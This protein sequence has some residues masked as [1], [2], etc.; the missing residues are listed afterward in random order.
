M[1]HPEPL[2]L[3]ELLA[4]YGLPPGTAGAEHGVAQEQFP[5][6]GLYGGTPRRIGKQARAASSRARSWRR[7]AVL[8]IGCPV[9]VPE[10]V[11][12]D[13]G[14]PVGD[15]IREPRELPVRIAL[16]TSATVRRR[17]ARSRKRRRSG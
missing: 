12:E 4:A 9:G 13:D 17:R 1:D 6:Q 16:R 14:D 2:V 15:G 8:V 11:G 3:V 10:S 7:S 5:G